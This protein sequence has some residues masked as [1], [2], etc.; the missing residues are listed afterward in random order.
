MPT[1]GSICARA[2]TPTSRSRE[3]LWPMMIAFWLSRSTM[4]LAWMSVIEPVSRVGDVLDRHGDRVRQLVAHALERRLA[5][6][7]GDAVLER[8]VGDDAVRIERRTRSA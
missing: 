7:L 1:S 8:L 6:D 5:D 4:T 2:R 3:P